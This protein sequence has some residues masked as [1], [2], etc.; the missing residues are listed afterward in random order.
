MTHYDILEVS[1]NAS[2]ETIRAAYKSL[3]QRYHPDRNPGNEGAADIARRITSAYGV[4]SDPVA[5]SSYD[6][7]LAETLLPEAS[8]NIVRIYSQDT[9]SDSRENIAKDANKDEVLQTTHTHF[10]FF[11]F[12]FALLLL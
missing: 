11:S 9:N 7:L 10:L 8:S 12:W 5:K 6:S 1:R 3:M 2:P 4:L